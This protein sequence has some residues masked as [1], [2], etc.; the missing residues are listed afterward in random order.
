[1][2]CVWSLALSAIANGV[3]VLPIRKYID[4]LVTN[5]PKIIF[6]LALT[7]YSL[8]IFIPT[9]GWLTGATLEHPQHRLLFV[10]AAVNGFVYGLIYHSLRK[11]TSQVE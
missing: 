3:F 2:I 11:P 4:K 10:T 7:F 8:I 1:M 9:L 5:I 6:A